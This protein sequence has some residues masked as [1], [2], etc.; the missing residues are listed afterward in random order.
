MLAVVGENT[1]LRC[2]KEINLNLKE[3]ILVIPA[4]K[5]S[6][7]Y[8]TSQSPQKTTM[9]VSEYWLKLRDILGLP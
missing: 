5:F 6:Q 7:D 2:I 9:C 1:V 8:R 4:T 3:T